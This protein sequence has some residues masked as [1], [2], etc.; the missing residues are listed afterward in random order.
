MAE[1]IETQEKK[2]EGKELVIEALKQ[3]IRIYRL[4]EKFTFQEGNKKIA[5]IIGFTKIAI[6]EVEK[7]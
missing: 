5:K 1:K 7:L 3:A 6:K 4:I 2:L